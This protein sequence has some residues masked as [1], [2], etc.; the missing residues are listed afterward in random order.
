[1]RL[2]SLGKVEVMPV[3]NGPGRFFLLL[4]FME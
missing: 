1:M 2:W 4:K 3:G